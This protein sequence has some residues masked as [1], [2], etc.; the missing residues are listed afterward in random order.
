MSI[1]NIILVLK[2]GRVVCVSVCV[3]EKEREAW[4]VGRSNESRIGWDVEVARFVRV[5]KSMG[6]Y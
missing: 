5:V 4:S 2:E 1:I 3:E 6:G